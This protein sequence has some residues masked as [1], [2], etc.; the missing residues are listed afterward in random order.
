MAA[1]RVNLRR[2]R[3]KAGLS[4]ENMARAVDT[5]KQTYHCAETGLRGIK[6]DLA[7]RIAERLGYDVAALRE[8]F[9]VV[10]VET[11]GGAE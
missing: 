4:Q 8:L 1:I 9:T 6:L 11:D 10:E 2:A 3:K 5:T 7:L